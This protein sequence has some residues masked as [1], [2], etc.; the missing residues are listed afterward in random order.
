MHVFFFNSRLLR[1]LGL[2][3]LSLLLQPQAAFAGPPD[4]SFPDQ[5]T[6]DR[7]DAAIIENF[8][9]QDAWGSIHMNTDADGMLD[10]G[11]PAVSGNDLD[12]TGRTPCREGANVCDKGKTVDLREKVNHVFTMQQAYVGH[13][14]KYD[15]KNSVLNCMSKV[16]PNSPIFNGGDGHPFQSNACSSY[17]LSIRDGGDRTKHP[18]SL[19]YMPLWKKNGNKDNCLQQVINNCTQ[20]VFSCDTQEDNKG[21][22]NPVEHV[23][24]QEDV[25]SLCGGSTSGCRLPNEYFRYKKEDK[26]HLTLDPNKRLDTGVSDWS[27]VTSKSND[28]ARIKAFTVKLDKNFNGDINKFHVVDP[29]NFFDLRDYVAGARF[30]SGYKELDSE[31]NPK[32]QDT[33][34]ILGVS[35][36][37]GI[38]DPSGK[39][40][41]NLPIYGVGAATTFTDKTG[42]VSNFENYPLKWSGYV[43]AW[44]F[45]TPDQYI[46]NTAHRRATFGGKLYAERAEINDNPILM[47]ER[48]EDFCDVRERYSGNVNPQVAPNLP[49]I[50]YKQY[51]A[52]PREGRAPLYTF[53]DLFQPGVDNGIKN[54]HALSILYT[55]DRREGKPVRDAKNIDFLDEAM[56]SVS[57]FTERGGFQNKDAVEF[58]DYDD[59][60]LQVRSTTGEVIQ[61]ASDNLMFEG[62]ATKQITIGIAD[63]LKNNG[64]AQAFPVEPGTKACFRLPSK[65]YQ[66]GDLSIAGKESTRCACVTHKPGVNG[67]E[68]NNLFV[69]TNTQAELA[70]FVEGSKQKEVGNLFVESC[71]PAYATFRQLRV[72]V[73]L[74]AARAAEIKDKKFENPNGTATWQ[75]TLRCDA[76]KEKPTCNETKLITA[77]RFCMLG[78]GIKG[79]C[80]DCAGIQGTEA[81]PDKDVDLSLEAVAGKSLAEIIQ[82][83]EIGG[84]ACFFKA[85]CFSVASAGCPTVGSSGGHIF[86]LTGD[87]KITMADGSQKEISKINPGEKVMA[88]DSEDVDSE[89]YPSEVQSLAVTREQRVIKVTLGN[90]KNKE[91]LKITPEHKVVLSSGR[92]LTANDL[93]KGDELLNAS[94]LPVEVTDMVFEEEKVTVYNLV[95][96]NDLDGYVA[97]GIRALSYP[98]KSR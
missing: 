29:S 14:I 2:F 73:R 16:V 71:A 11:T 94:G 9:W 54:T 55:H 40:G 64:N 28:L 24:S 5:D 92:I 57:T 8:D 22:T 84:D 56:P 77:Q 35:G 26:Y 1:A 6:N 72:G 50:Q 39:A 76:L 43:K 51:Q 97:S 30:D 48:S 33:C 95:L 17:G 46:A 41:C 88:F 74:P 18:L 37:G 66:P 62:E 19:I 85:A 13:G 67:N 45:I 80:G 25:A 4:F 78:D 91:F 82:S 38:C 69:P 70:S 15:I 53:V 90:A 34:P 36:Y 47:V 60:S 12:S 65:T 87:T 52:L 79:K 44:K 42:H 98:S 7:G 83:P 32:S 89:L 20:D 3:I 93:R 27:K 68:R 75:G 86:C 63:A 49:C 21:H 61:W 10:P 96:E 58:Y 81:D 23:F 31:G 59:P